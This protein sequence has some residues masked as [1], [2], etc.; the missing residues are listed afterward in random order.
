[1]ELIH[2][3][4]QVYDGNK[5]KEIK[6]SWT[7]PN[8]GLWT[9]PVDS[10]YGW[11]DWCKSENFRDCNIENS[12]RL[13]LNIGAKICKID[14]LEDLLN[15]PIYKTYPRYLDFEKIS[16]IYDCIWLTVNG[17]YDTRYSEPNLYGWDCESVLLLNDKCFS[18]C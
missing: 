17:Q 13:K 3:G 7:K 9:S 12:F 11:Y 10:L 2:Y 16:L 14:T 15:L 4:S 18:P 1:M 6:N 5:F 8:G